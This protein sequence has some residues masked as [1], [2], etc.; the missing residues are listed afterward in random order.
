MEV[1]VEAQARHPFEH[2]YADFL[3]GTRV[4]SGFVDHDVAALEH[5][6]YGFAGAHQRCEVGLLVLVD[7]GRHGDDEHIGLGQGLGIGRVAQLRGRCQFV[8]VDFKRVVAA[9]LELVYSAGV[10]VETQHRTPLA[11]FDGQR[12]T[13]IAQ[14]HH[15]EFHLFDSQHF[16]SLHA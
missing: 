13:D 8:G 10:D 15:G 4:D 2:R 1:F 6:P 11:E 12:Q 3:G 9:F 16:S 7:G 14:A 5:P